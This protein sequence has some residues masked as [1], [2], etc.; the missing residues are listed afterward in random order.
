ML[1]VAVA[2]ASG[3]ADEPVVPTSTTAAATSSTS[4]PTAPSTST[5]TDS[6][7]TVP[8]T[9]VPPTTVPPP[10]ESSEPQGPVVD[11]RFF[12]DVLDLRRDEGRIVMLIDYAE[13]LTGEEAAEAAAEAGQESPP[14]NDYFIRNVNPRLREIEVD[15]A[16]GVRINVCYP[17]GE[18]VTTVDVDSAQWLR[19][20][21]GDRTGIDY[22]WYG[23]G[24]LPYWITIEGGR[25]VDIV[26]QYLP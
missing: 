15:T 14:P 16:A 17:E 10:T 6:S 2:C 5:T 3:E 21:E 12:G 9:A 19:L 25:V 7:T 1:A 11:G 22:Q 26:E 20:F 18:C 23:D 8:P 13:F 4:A 24:H